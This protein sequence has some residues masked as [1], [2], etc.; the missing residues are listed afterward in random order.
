MLRKFSY[1][2]GIFHFCT[3]FKGIR[4]CLLSHFGNGSLQTAGRELQHLMRRRRRSALGLVLS[5]S[6]DGFLAPGVA[7]DFLWCSGCFACPETLDTSS[8]VF[9]VGNPGAGGSVRAGEACVEFLST[10]EMGGGPDSHGL[11]A[12][13]WGAG[14][15]PSPAART[16]PGK[17][18][19]THTASALR[20]RGRLSS[21]P[22]ATDSRERGARESASL[23]PHFLPPSC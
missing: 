7:S 18:A 16:F 15:A 23:P 9:A 19:L 10:P 8:S 11:G 22:S 1:F 2:A 20:V 5:R 21:P 14:S 17:Q 6:A 12:D 4:N 13:R 3:G